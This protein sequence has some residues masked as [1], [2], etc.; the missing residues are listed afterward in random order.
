MK[1]KR[2]FLYTFLAALATLLIYG[3]KKNASFQTD[4][5]TDYVQMSVG[6]YITYRL[7]SLLFINF[8]TQDT[9]ISYQARDVVDAPVTDAQGRPGWRVIRYLSDTTGSLPWTPTE[10]YMVTVTSQAVEVVENNLRYIK[11]E[12]PIVDGFSWKGN[13][14]IDTQSPISQVPYLDNWDYTYANTGQP[15]SVWAGSIPITTTVNQRADSTNRID[16]V[17]SYF[18]KNYSKEVYGKGIGLIYKYF[19]HSEFQGPNDNSSAGSTSGYGLT[20]SMID[21]N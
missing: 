13:S 1:K 2:Y 16:T 21:H 7:D 8:G 11:L 20:L 10:A 5:L 15:F 14:Y 17:Y 18:E 19:L 3:C 9:I 12:L 4:Q 6:K